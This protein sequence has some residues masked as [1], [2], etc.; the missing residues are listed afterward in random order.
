[1]RNGRDDGNDFVN[2]KSEGLVLVLV[3]NLPASRMQLCK[4]MSVNFASTQHI[5]GIAWHAAGAIFTHPLQIMR[6]VSASF[7]LA[8]IPRPKALALGAKHLVASLRF[9]N[10]NLA[11]GARFSVLLQQSDGSKSV[12]I[13]NM[14]VIIPI[15]LEFPAMCTRVFVTCSTLPSG[16][17]K[18]IAVGI[19]TAMNELLNMFNVVRALSYQLVLGS[20]QV[21]LECLKLLDLSDDVL[22]L[23]I[24]VINEPVMGNSSLCGREHGLFLSE[25][26]VLLVL[27]ELTVEK[28]LGKSEMLNLRMCE[29]S[30]AK[31]ALGH[32]DVVATEERF[33]T[34]AA[35]ALGTSVER[36]KNGFAIGRIERIKADGTGHIC[37]RERLNGITNE[38]KCR[39]GME[40]IFWNLC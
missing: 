17:H 10:E 33:I 3:L 11:I 13:A 30:V 5:V 25:E 4:E 37:N 31:D 19:S 20:I 15:G 14:C 39:K 34:S 18:A 35:S 38:R 2:V 24:D 26:N 40:S 8:S 21:I 1:M 28:G 36:A 6:I 32:G 29:R 23:C 22:Y 27:G 16:R 7:K 9:V 12:W